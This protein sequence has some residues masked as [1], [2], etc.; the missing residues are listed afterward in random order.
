MRPIA[1]PRVYDPDETP[2]VQVE[3]SDTSHIV[4]GFL[5]IAASGLSIAALTWLLVCLTAISHSLQL[6]AGG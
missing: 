1:I 4:A 6:L 2:F 5:V 3:Q